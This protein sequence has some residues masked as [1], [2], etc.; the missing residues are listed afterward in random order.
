VAVELDE[1][2]KVRT[3][4]LEDGRTPVQRYATAEQAALE[5]NERAATSQ[6]Q[7]EWRA[8]QA[9][10]DASVSRAAL[11]QYLQANPNGAYA[12]KAKADLE[13]SLSALTVGNLEVDA[14]RM[15]EGTGGQLSFSLTSRTFTVGQSTHKGVESFLGRG[16]PRSAENSGGLAGYLWRVQYKRGGASFSLWDAISGGPP[17]G[18]VILFF[19]ASDV[20]QKIEEVD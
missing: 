5:V 6:R 15:V 18:K 12:E 14:S 16:D 10:K 17:F 2:R 1:G 7:E 9:Y 8:A 20:L 11:K 4:N 3:V 19:D 13:V